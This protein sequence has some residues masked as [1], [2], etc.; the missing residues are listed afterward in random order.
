M[1]I[2]TPKIKV[3]SKVSVPDPKK[4]DNWQHSFQGRVIKIDTD[5]WEAFVVDQD[6]DVY[7]LEVER[8][9]VLD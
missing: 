8:M 9:I 1:Y 3:G 5:N 2:K 7:C 4:D 6:D